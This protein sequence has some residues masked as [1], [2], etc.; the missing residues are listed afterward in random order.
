MNRKF[1]TSIVATLFFTFGIGGLF[2]NHV[3]SQPVNQT[4][5][6]D[7][8]YPNVCIK[9]PPPDLNCSDVSGEQFKVLPPDPHGFDRDGNGIGCEGDS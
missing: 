9:S 1:F 3:Y 4:R 5:N 6:C 8:A 2:P 7:P